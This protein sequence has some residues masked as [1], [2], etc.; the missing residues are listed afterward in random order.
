[1]VGAMGRGKERDWWAKA[2]AWRPLYRFV[3]AGLA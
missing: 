2:A 1:M 3:R